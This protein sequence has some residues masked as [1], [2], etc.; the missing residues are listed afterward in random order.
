VS[1][2][3]DRPDAPQVSI[4]VTNCDDSGAGSLRDALAMNPDVVDMTQL[5]C[6]AI[7]LT[8][9]ELS[10]QADNLFVLGRG[11]TISANGGS[12][13]L[14]HHGR[15]D[16][17]I[18]G[19]R[20]TDGAV[21]STNP[22]LGGCVY[23]EG[24]VY[25]TDVGVENCYVSSAPGDTSSAAG[26]GVFARG[27]VHTFYSSIRNNSVFPAGGAYSFSNGGGIFAGGTISL[28]NTTVSGN[29]AAGTSGYT[30]GG[31][32]YASSSAF[33][34]YSTISANTSASGGG[35]MMGNGKSVS[36]IENSTV[37]GNNG[38]GSAGIWSRDGELRVWNSTIAFNVATR[39]PCGAGLIAS[40]GTEYLIFNNAIIA[41]NTAGGFENDLCFQSFEGG[42]I[43]GHANLIVQSDV[44]LPPDT[45]RSDPMLGPLADNGGLTQTHALLVGS[46]AID[47][48][49][50]AFNH[51]TYDQ[52]GRG[53][54]RVSGP[55][56]DIGAFEVQ[57]PPPPNEIF[58]NGFD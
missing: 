19:V 50:D 34:S 10:T 41:D 54:A 8:S 27:S 53:F 6:S 22:A 30:S 13:V 25:L 55:H 17:R 40:G 37:S 20:F 9:G 7:T 2:A 49:S 1:S 28:S 23:S 33:I 5:T 31:G 29:L 38:E 45:I 12:R 16:L 14:A 36:A 4:V 43:I 46:P 32:L 3:E 39:G 47:A 35:A 26:G 58:A 15:G 51:S 48:G 42:A 56:V 52:R 11:M 18:S 44:T 24:T 21:I 57:Q